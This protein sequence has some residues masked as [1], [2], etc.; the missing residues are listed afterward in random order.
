MTKV[1]TRRGDWDVQVCWQDFVE[2]ARH[3]RIF[4]YAVLL[5][6]HLF[7]WQVDNYKSKQI[8]NNFFFPR[9]NLL[10]WQ[11]FE[12]I[13]MFTTRSFESNDFLQFS[14]FYNPVL[15]KFGPSH[16]DCIY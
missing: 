5:H 12:E 14:I 7:V 8:L 16:S 9:I 13:P 4:A 1:C 15:N 11:I 2:I 6:I 10:I 3:V